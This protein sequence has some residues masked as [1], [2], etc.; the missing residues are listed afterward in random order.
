MDVDLFSLVS[1]SAM[2]N[3]CRMIQVCVQNYHIGGYNNAIPYENSSVPLKQNIAI[4][5]NKL[6]NINIFTCRNRAINPNVP[7]PEM[8]IRT[9]FF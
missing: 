5:G 2:L 6:A 7:F 4:Y 3:G 8:V 1:P 9:G